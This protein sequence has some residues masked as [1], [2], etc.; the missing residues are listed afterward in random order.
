MLL[1][2]AVGR[3]PFCCH[4]NPTN[5]CGPGS[6][7]A[8]CIFW[9]APN[10]ASHAALIG[11][12]LVVML[13]LLSLFSCSLPPAMHIPVV[14]L[15]PS[16]QVHTCKAAT[17]C[18]CPQ[19]QHKPGS[20]LQ[21]GMLKL[22]SV[23]AAIRWAI[24]NYRSGVANGRGWR[25]WCRRRLATC[26]PPTAGPQRQQHGTRVPSQ[27]LPAAGVD[28][29]CKALAA[30]ADACTQQ[31]QPFSVQ[32]TAPCAHV[33]GQQRL[34]ACGASGSSTASAGLTRPCRR[35]ARPAGPVSVEGQRAE[36]Q[37]ES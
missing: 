31:C 23:A 33:P 4:C 25:F 32:G 18:K 20:A 35:P 15:S 22:F 13:L 3:V 19:L 21:Q 11:S 10:S 36:R 7:P 14:L 29:Q 5:H 6:L 28:K 27:P 34:T 9:R 30:V 26:L 12:C 1:P 17:A 8:C 16:C 24:L 2:F 37:V